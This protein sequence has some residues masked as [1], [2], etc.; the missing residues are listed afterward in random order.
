MI[1]NVQVLFE[2]WTR[3][4]TST[5]DVV[6]L[7]K[8]WFIYYFSKRAMLLQWGRAIG[9]LLGKDVQNR[10]TKIWQN[11]HLGICLLHPSLIVFRHC[12]FLAHRLFLLLFV[13]ATASVEKRKKWVRIKK[14]NWSKIKHQ[15]TNSVKMFSLNLRN[16][17]K[18][19]WTRPQRMRLLAFGL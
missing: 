6:W 3:R 4:N 17:I 10:Q 19:N 5:K 13:K 14:I 1:T 11:T 9:A 8:N 12:S 15:K 7:I 16:G 2:S 18:L